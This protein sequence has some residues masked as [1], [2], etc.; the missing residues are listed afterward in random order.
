[1][2]PSTCRWGSG[3]GGYCGFGGLFGGGGGPR[4]SRRHALAGTSGCTPVPPRGVTSLLEASF[5]EAVEAAFPDAGVATHGDVQPSAPPAAAPDRPTSAAAYFVPEATRAVWDGDVLTV[6]F[7]EAGLVA[8]AVTTVSVSGEAAA[9]AVATRDDE[10]IFSLH[11]HS[12]VADES[13]YPVGADGTA[14]ST[15]VLRLTAQ[16]AALDGIDC[17]MNVNHSF[18]VTVRDLDT[19]AVLHMSGAPEPDNSRG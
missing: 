19:G 3:D 4:I 5:E 10:V 15:V 1:M 6:T 18:S 11:S 13:A 7:R 12:A 17:T 9:D 14:D 8:D 16:V 2:A